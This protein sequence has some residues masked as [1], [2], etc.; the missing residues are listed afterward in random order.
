MRGDRV[1]LTKY[2]IPVRGVRNVYLAGAFGAYADRDRIVTFGITP[3]FPDAEFHAI[4]NGSLTGALAVL[5]SEKKRQEALDVAKKMVYIDL[6]VD[7]DFIEGYASAIYIP[8]KPEY[9]SH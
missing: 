1:L 7:A 6:L 5:L 3:D 9:F 4:G 2:H 8:G